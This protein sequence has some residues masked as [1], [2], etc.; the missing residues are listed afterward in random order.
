MTIVYTRVV[1]YVLSTLLASIP[2]FSLGWFSYEYVNEMIVVTLSPEGLVNTL[3]GGGLLS[4]GIFKKW[5]V[6]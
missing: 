1:L 4:L 2:S 6:K 3:M 5:G